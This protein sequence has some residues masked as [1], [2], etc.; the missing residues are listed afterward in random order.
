MHREIVE[1]NEFFA[2]LQ[3]LGDIE[4]VDDAL[5]AA[6]WALSRT[7]ENYPCIFRD[8]RMLKTYGTGELPPLSVR[9]RLEGEQVVL[10]HVEPT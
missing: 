7:P 9:F 2:Q 6:Y 1:S 4:R 3:S 8:I 10:L 5:S